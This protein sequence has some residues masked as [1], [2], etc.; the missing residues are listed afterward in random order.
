[1]RFRE[2]KIF[3]HKKLTQCNIS[4]CVNEHLKLMYFLYFTV[5]LLWSHPYTLILNYVCIQIVLVVLIIATAER[6][7]KP[8]QTHAKI[9]SL[10]TFNWSKFVDPIFPRDRF[11]QIMSLSNYEFVK[12]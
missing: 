8:R 12:L 6:D 7:S 4:L 1:M 3:C 11:C 9:G 10:S 5:Y 2:Q